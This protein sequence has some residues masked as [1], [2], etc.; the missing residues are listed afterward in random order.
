VQRFDGILGDY[1]VSGI[2]KKAKRSNARI[3][4][5]DKPV[6]DLTQSLTLANVR[7]MSL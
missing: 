3:S 1:G 7:S 6:V 4:S 2:L 5:Q